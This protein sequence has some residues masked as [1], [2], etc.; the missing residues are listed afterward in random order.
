[1]VA[2]A[3]VVVVVVVVVAV[4]SVVGMTIEGFVYGLYGLRQSALYTD[5]GFL[6]KR[7]W[8]W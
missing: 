3:V 8:R 1:M 7:P 5:A 6:W 2:V 4:V